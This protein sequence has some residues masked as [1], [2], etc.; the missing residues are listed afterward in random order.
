MP[1]LIKSDPLHMTEGVIEA[2]CIYLHT[3]KG[4]V[5]ASW[6]GL[7]GQCTLPSIIRWTPFDVDLSGVVPRA[8][9]GFP[10]A[11]NRVISYPY[12]GASIPKTRFGFL[13]PRTTNVDQ[14]C[15]FKN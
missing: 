9:G 15:I 6:S 8:H 13:A 3:P 4:H 1:L 11:V 14:G 10:W 5:K 12:D 2:T 7:N